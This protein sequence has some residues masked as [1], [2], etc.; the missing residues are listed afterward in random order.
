M[1]DCEPKMH[2]HEPKKHFNEP[3]TLKNTGKICS[4][5]D[6]NFG[7]KLFVIFLCSPQKHDEGTY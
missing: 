5:S 2:D 4:R 7:N 6:E 3:D 1:H